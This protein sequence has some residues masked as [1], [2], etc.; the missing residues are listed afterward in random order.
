MDF[1]PIKPADYETVRQFLAE[2]GWQKRVEDRERFQKMMENAS[3]TIIAF[4]GE[5]VVGFAHRFENKLLEVF[6]LKGKDNRWE[7]SYR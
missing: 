6:L 3:R 4:E 5:R 7:T 2:N 1:R